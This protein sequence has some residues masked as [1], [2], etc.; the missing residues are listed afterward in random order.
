MFVT[1]FFISVYDGQGTSRVFSTLEKAV[2]YC[3]SQNAPDYIH[4]KDPFKSDYGGWVIE[5][6]VVDAVEGILKC[7][8]GNGIAFKTVRGIW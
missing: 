2:Q 5:E 3:N 4:P 1:Y 6:H 7:Y 8:N